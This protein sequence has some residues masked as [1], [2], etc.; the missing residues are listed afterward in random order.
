[1]KYSGYSTLNSDVCI[2]DP[3]S[4]YGWMHACQELSLCDAVPAC[5][6]LRVTCWQVRAQ[7]INERKRNGS[8]LTGC[9]NWRRWLSGYFSG[10]YKRILIALAGLFTAKVLV[11][12]DWI[13]LI[14]LVLSV[15]FSSLFDT[16]SGWKYQG[17]RWT[18]KWPGIFCDLHKPGNNREFF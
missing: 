13:L 8:G 9:G 1:M 14:S 17:S 3:E 4:M 16:F 6:V 12:R 15:T 2:F 5:Y 11:T 7:T 10:N 18:G